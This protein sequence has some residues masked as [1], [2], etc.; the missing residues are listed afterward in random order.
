MKAQVNNRANSWNDL[1]NIL[2]AES[3]PTDTTQIKGNYTHAE[4]PPELGYRLTV[5]IS[6][7]NDYNGY[8]ASYREYQRGDH[9]R[10]ALTGW[11]PHSSDYM[12]TRLVDMGG[13]LNGGPDLADEPGQEKVVPDVALN[14]QRASNLGEVGETIVAAYEASLPDDGG[15]AETIQQPSDIERFSATFFKW[16]GGSNFTDNPAVKVQRQVDGQWVDFAD[17]SGEIPVTVEYPQGEDV[18]SYLEGDQHWKWTAHFE[19]FATNYDLGM[20]GGQLATPAGAYRFV[21]DGERREGGSRRSYHLESNTF[22]VKPWTGITASDVRIDPGG[23]ISFKIGPRHTYT[24][25]GIAAELGPIDY[26]D[27]YSSPARFIKNER[28]AYRDP[29]APTDP[30]KFEWFCFTCTFRNW[31]DTGDAEVAYL[32]IVDPR[33]G[34]YRYKARPRGD[35]WSVTRKL[36]P[37][38]SAYVRAGDVRDGFGNYNGADSERLSGSS[39]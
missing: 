31:A 23:R 24:A 36:R 6:M 7:A 15:Q 27:S 10:K 20:G 21:V 30:Q 18:Q 29:S 37:R 2:W 11:G 25:Y 39:G 8:I 1:E 16:N 35:R 5:P 9:Y 14:D 17:Q 32:T 12:A 3:E 28:T 22:E 38:E 34:L 33:G 19:A 13:H 4:L 26:P